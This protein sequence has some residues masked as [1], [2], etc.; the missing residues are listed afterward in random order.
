MPNAESKTKVDWSF[1]TAGRNHPLWS[2]YRVVEVEILSESAN[3]KPNQWVHTCSHQQTK[4]TQSRPA[5][6]IFHVQ[7][8]SNE[9]RKKTLEKMI[10]TLIKGNFLWALHSYHI[11]RTLFR[12]IKKGTYWTLIWEWSEYKFS[13]RPPFQAFCLR[14]RQAE[15]F[16]TAFSIP[17]GHQRDDSIKKR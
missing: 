12:N 8:G 15:G 10:E 13:W 1:L 2:K 5:T 9:N 16:S 3:M 14:C 17:Q 4:V 6:Q 7:W 11:R